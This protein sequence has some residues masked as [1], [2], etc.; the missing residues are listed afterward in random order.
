M[1]LSILASALFL[2]AAVEMWG[3]FPLD[4]VNDGPL[5]ST[6]MMSGKMEQDP[7]VPRT[8]AIV[9]HFV[10]RSTLIIQLTLTSGWIWILHSTTAVS[11][12]KFHQFL[13]Q[14]RYI[15]TY[16]MYFAELGVF[17]LN[18]NICLLFSSM[19]AATTH[20]LVVLQLCYYMPIALIFLGCLVIHCL[21][22]VWPIMDC[23]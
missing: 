9:Y 11:T 21:S 8:L 17:L 18:A 15:F 3:A 10:A 12:L 19:L 23:Y 22:D 2:G 14:I 16:I 5:W 6:D 4:N 1:E 7:H 20:D 13:L